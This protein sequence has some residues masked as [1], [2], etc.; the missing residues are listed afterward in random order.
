MAAIFWG[1]SAVGNLT[2]GDQRIC[3]FFNL[4]GPRRDECNNR[5]N[6]LAFARA[7]TGEVGE[8]CF[9]SYRFAVYV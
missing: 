4:S 5:C 8:A 2:N 7:G 1:P 3:G 9:F 6:L